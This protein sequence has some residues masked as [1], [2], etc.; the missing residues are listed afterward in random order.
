MVQT[1]TKKQLEIL[2]SKLK[3]NPNPRAEL[4][5]YTIP[6][7]LAAQIINVA[8]LSG[9][10]KGKYIIDFGC[11]SGRLTIGSA[12]MN[13][14]KVIGIDIDKKV[15]KIANENVRLAEIL[16]KQKIQDRIKFLK[17]DVSDWKEEVDTVI[18]NPPFGIQKLHADRLFIK[19]ALKCGN[20]IYTLHRGSYKKTCE[21]LKKFIEVNGGELEKIIKF[22]FRIPYMFKF[23]RKPYVSY[24]VDLFIISRV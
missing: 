1:L 11:G 2:L 16:T 6:S 24:D 3:E 7:E 13:A 10:I 4:E 14:K 20:R 19:K 9:D 5:Q 22:K 15:L 21:F 18:Q 12:L 23:H 8:Y 17:K